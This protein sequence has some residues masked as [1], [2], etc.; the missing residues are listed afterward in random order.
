MRGRSGTSI[1]LGYG[2]TWNSNNTASIIQMTYQLSMLYD[3]DTR[4]HMPFLTNTENEDSV[5]DGQSCSRRENDAKAHHPRALIASGEVLNH[6]KLGRR[7]GK[8]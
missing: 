7:R 3:T 1:D 6:M 5:V 4:S 8:S 2:C